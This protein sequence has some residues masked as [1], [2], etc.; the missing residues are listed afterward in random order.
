M[1]TRPQFHSSGLQPNGSVVLELNSKMRR[2]LSRLLTG[3]PDN[4]IRALAGN[5]ASS[6]KALGE[7]LGET[8][9]ASNFP[10]TTEPQR[11]AIVPAPD[12]VTSSPHTHRP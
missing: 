10:D 12:F 1:R 2:I 5:V 3:L 9:T 11:T 6:V 4:C 8:E 7:R